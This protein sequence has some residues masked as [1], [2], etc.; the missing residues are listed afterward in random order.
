MTVQVL[1]GVGYLPLSEAGMGARY[2]KSRRNMR[3]ANNTETRQRYCVMRPIII[4]LSIYLLTDI[5]PV[6]DAD[7]LHLTFI[8]LLCWET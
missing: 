2:G 6:G 1:A 5:A 4:L 3:K 8:L 7:T